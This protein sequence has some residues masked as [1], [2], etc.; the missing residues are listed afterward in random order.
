MI[1]PVVCFFAVATGISLQ[2]NAR[3]SD[4]LRTTKRS[5]M[6]FVLHVWPKRLFVHAE[7]PVNLHVILRNVSG[8]DQFI[9][10]FMRPVPFGAD[11]D[12]GSLMT[13]CRNARAGKDVRYKWAPPGMTTQDAQ[14]KELVET[15]PAGSSSSRETINLR[16][17]C[18]LPRG[19]YIVEMQFETQHLPTWIKPD[20]RAWHGVTNVEKVLIHII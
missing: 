19:T 3:A 10:C 8:T 4:T 18:V 7:H 14:M 13:R 6:P 15:C 16:D 5:N 12:M 2:L 17:W 20:K 11:T 9:W 1:R